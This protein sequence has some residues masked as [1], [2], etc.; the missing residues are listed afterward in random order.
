MHMVKFVGLK[1][2]DYSERKAE[3]IFEANCRNGEITTSGMEDGIKRTRQLF[4]NRAYKEMI[5]N[6]GMYVRDKQ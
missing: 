4:D 1:N 2:P 5:V 3:Q 6:S